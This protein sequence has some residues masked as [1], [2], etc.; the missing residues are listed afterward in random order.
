[1][2]QPN[3]FEKVNRTHL[4]C[5]WS[6]ITVVQYNTQSYFLSKK[7]KKNTSFLLSLKYPPKPRKPKAGR[8]T[9]PAGLLVVASW[10]SLW[11]VRVCV[12]VVWIWAWKCVAKGFMGRVC[13]IWFWWL[14]NSGLQAQIGPKCELIQTHI[15]WCHYS[16]TSSWYMFHIY[17]HI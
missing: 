13:S 14:D 12:F 9:S 15:W 1:M 2:E 7:I 16:N 17:N 10:S 6:I 3:K 5:A 11:L 8:H 4:E